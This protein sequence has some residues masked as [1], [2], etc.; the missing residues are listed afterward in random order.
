MK[1]LQSHKREPDST[2]RRPAGVPSGGANTS[3]CDPR[4]YRRRIRTTVVQIPTTPTVDE[5]ATATRVRYCGA[6]PRTQITDLLPWV[7]RESTYTATVV[8][9]GPSAANRS[10][11]R[12]P[13][14]GHWGTQ[15]GSKRWSRRDPFWS[16][17]N[18]PVAAEELNTLSSLAGCR[19]RTAPARGSVTG[20]HPP[21]ARV[22]ASTRLIPSQELSH[23]APLHP[24]SLPGRDPQHPR[25]DR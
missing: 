3:C 19:P 12:V 17:P 4:R 8:G 22:R 15:R 7:S 9:V 14:I 18:V 16:T 24:S 10:S 23:P 2:K 6:R 11:N 20:T 13:R 25:D 5:R 1:G 21:R